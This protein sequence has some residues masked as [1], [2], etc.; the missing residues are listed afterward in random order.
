MFKSKGVMFLILV[1]M[2]MAFSCSGPESDQPLLTA[3]LPLH[4]EEHL[5]SARI[6][7][8][9]VPTDVLDPVEWRFDEP[10]PEWKP[11]VPRI[12][13]VKPI[14]VTRTEDALRLTLTD[15]QRLQ[16]RP[17]AMRW[18]SIY[19]DL[20]D[21]RLADWGTVLI[22]GRTSDWTG[23]LHIQFNLVDAPD[24]RIGVRY[25]ASV[26]GEYDVPV[27]SD[28]LV[29]T[30]ALRT[31]WLWSYV[32]ATQGNPWGWRPAWSPDW[33]EPWQQLGI[34]L[35]ARGSEPASF[36]LLSVTIMPSEMRYAYEPVG[37][38][39]EVRNSAHRRTLY[40]HAP[41]R[42]EYRVRVPE[43]GR[44]D[45][46]LGV[47]RSDTPVRFRVIV[48]P[49]G[50]EAETLLEESYADQRR[51]AQRSVDLSHLAGRIATLALE[52]DAERVGTVALWSAPTLTGART[53]E[54]P[55][56][57]FY[58][59]DGGGAD[60]MSVYGY[61]RRTTPNLERLA[62]EGA[63]FEH[64][65]SNATWTVPSTGS[66]VTSLHTSVLGGYRDGNE[67]MIPEQTAPMAERM[68]RAG[69]QTAV[70]TTNPW[71]GTHTGLD[72]GVDVLRDAGEENHSLSSVELHEDYWRW[73]QAYPGEPY[74]V[75]FQ[76]TGADAPFEPARPFDPFAGLYVSPELRERY[77]EWERQ[78]EKA[79]GDL[80]ALP[81]SAVFA[82]AGIDPVAHFHA[83]RGL[84][85]E[86]MAHQ[87]YQ[88]GRLVE[89]LKAAGEWEHT[90]LI[91]AADHGDWLDAPG[92]PG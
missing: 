90:L 14:D 32:G 74:F 54:K 40:T 10:Q 1:I 75:H 43:A 42:L 77:F 36:D 50:G 2:L 34:I 86:A 17:D 71:A 8:S 57:I 88:L 3:E 63:V 25:A 45:L 52:A 26:Q 44:L 13:S 66:F 28:G 53:T 80:L 79:L 5:D 73:R 16:W 64:V 23:P 60:H 84:L 35:T 9:E 15:A 19:V 30:Y 67:R 12:N 65:Y 46:G 89:R 21:Y 37:V 22:R 39:T 59:I 72:R 20:P 48:E 4:L 81:D 83:K 69:Y 24:S 62:G 18:G 6:E 27:V 31:D 47:V 78:L 49:Q 11:I 56:I 87:D 7:G 70:L 82:E 29:H 58:V 92:G 68:H 55:N 91:V 51:W 33:E 85:D 76:T 38:R 61:N 41:G